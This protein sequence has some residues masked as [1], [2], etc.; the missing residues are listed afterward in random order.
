MKIKLDEIAPVLVCENVSESLKFYTEK[1]GCELI[2]LWDEDHHYAIL[3]LDGKSIHLSEHSSKGFQT[4][5]I[6]CQDIQS[7]H[8]HY[9]SKNIHSITELQLQPWNRIE[10]EITDLDGNVMIFGAMP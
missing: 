2:F 3:D 10:F 4:I 6:S 8:E 7:L 1:I 5:Y 9:K